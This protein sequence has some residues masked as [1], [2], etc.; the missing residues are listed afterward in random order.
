M[1]WG[2]KDPGRINRAEG[3]LLAL[4]YLTYT[5]WLLTTLSPASA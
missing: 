2:F 3:G 5:G 4:A 1:G